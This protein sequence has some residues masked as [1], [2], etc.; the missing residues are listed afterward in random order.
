[1]IVR[2][3]GIEEVE[4][5]EEGLN[6]NMFFLVVVVGF[7]EFDVSLGWGVFVRVLSLAKVM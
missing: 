7:D 2:G 3:V 4:V 6:L 5:E 1:M